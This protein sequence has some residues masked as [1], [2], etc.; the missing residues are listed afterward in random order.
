MCGAALRALFG[1]GIA[2]SAGEVVVLVCQ[3][4]HTR[5]RPCCMPPATLCVF[6]LPA[7]ANECGLSSCAVGGTISYTN[8]TCFDRPA[9]LTGFDCGCLSG[10]NWNGTA[11]EGELVT[12]WMA[13]HTARLGPECARHLWHDLLV[14]A[15]MHEASSLGIGTARH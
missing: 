3:H 9:P 8:G 11:C 14:G 13:W 7:D 5:C 2:A 1:I 12:A 6:F 4:T 15:C 10:Y